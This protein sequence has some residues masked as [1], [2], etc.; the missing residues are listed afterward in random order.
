MMMEASTGEVRR[1]KGCC[2]LDCQDT[3]AWVAH[4]ADG[5]VVR[6]EGAQDHPFTRGVLCAKVNDYEQRT[7][8]EDRLLH[9]LRRCGPKGS[10]SFERISWDAAL[11]EIAHRFSTISARFGPEALLPI[12]YLGSMGVVQRRALMRLFHA[13]GT[14]VF[15]GSICGASGNALEAEGHPRGF[16]PEDIAESRFVLLWGA[17][18]LSTS[19]H[20]WHFVNEAR[21]RHGARIVSIDPTKTRTARQCDEHI[22]I[23][24]GSD[25]VLAAGLAHV[26]VE[27]GL[28]DQAFVSQVA[29]DGEAFRQQVLPWTPD[30]VARICGIDAGV[31]VRIAREFA[32]A[33]P[34]VIRCGVAPQQTVGGEAFVRA[35][36]ALAILGGHWRLPGGGLFMETVPAMDESRAARPDLRPRPSRSLDIA[37][38]GEH[39]TSDALSPPVMGLMVWGTNPAVVQPDAERMRAGLARE[40]LFT[41]VIEHF[42]TDTARFADLVLPSTTQLEH[43]DVQ[44]AWGHHYISV[45]N[46]AVPPLGEAKAHGEIMRLLA[47]RLGLDHPALRETDEEIAAA[48]LPAGIDLPSLKAQGWHKSSP[49][50]P[51]FDPARRVRI[52]GDVPLP[53]EPPDAGML[54]LLTPKS[55]HFMNSSFANMPRQ[56]T[57]MRRPTLEMHPLDADARG[58]IDGMRVDLRNARGQLRVSVRVTGD[59]HQGVVV[60]PGKWWSF[61]EESGA[62]ANLLTPSAWSP[63]GQ[64]AYNDTFVEVT[65]VH[66]E[67]PAA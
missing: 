8:A 47:R 2:P 9:P 23:R 38:L 22:S 59:V 51:A 5:R 17:N 66:G 13:L 18:L 33:R 39:L 15:H 46:P 60:L 25:A 67:S 65:A 50:Q 42:L 49:V 12:N 35:L 27:E 1:V 56:R 45:N 63:G 16:D 28:A 64:P 58:V 21:K 30:R 7:Y 20:H 10:A 19:H 26:I 36:S 44:G 40:D 43:F 52:S 34:A 32:A 55:H 11:D 3:C 31:V 14:S 4:V 57:A 24:P 6:V 37:R 54:Q 61:P 48:V 62:L 41:V 29:D 53:P